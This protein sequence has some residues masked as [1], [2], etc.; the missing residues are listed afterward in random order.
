ML[1]LEMRNYLAEVSRVLK[2]NGRCVLT[3]YLRNGESEKL[4]AEG[5]SRFAFPHAMRGYWTTNPRAPED[6]TCFEESEV[7]GLIDA[8]GME[9]LGPIHFGKWSGR[10]GTLSYQDILICQKRTTGKLAYPYISNRRRI[11]M[12]VRRILRFPLQKLLWRGA[13][14]AQVEE[15]LRVAQP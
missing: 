11:A 10:T 1:P 7:S 12:Q 6:L 2:V 9:I 15:A 5:K 4:R 8:N 3:F 13:T 14:I